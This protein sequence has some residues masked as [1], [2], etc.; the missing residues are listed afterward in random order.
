M[1]NS[2]LV[3]RFIP[4]QS[5][6]WILSPGCRTAAQFE[7]VR[8]I[9][10]GPDFAYMCSPDW[11]TRSKQERP[12]AISTLTFVFGLKDGRLR[13]VRVSPKGRTTKEVTTEK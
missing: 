13:A 8:A 12:N 4:S 2:L 10:A 9:V 6:T 3:H 1:T 11:F 7:A 5:E